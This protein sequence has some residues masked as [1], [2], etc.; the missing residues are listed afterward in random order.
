MSRLKRSSVSLEKAERRA[1][2]M[3]AISNSLDLGNGLTLPAYT[4]AIDALRRH[5]MDYNSLLSSLDKS[6]SE[7]VEMERQIADLSEHMLMGVATKYGKSSTEYEMAGGVRKTNRKNSRSTG[8]QSG[9]QSGKETV[10][11]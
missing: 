1:A 3:Q 8:S 5:L 7:L 11:A 2:A 10:K 9:S 6:Y 4:T